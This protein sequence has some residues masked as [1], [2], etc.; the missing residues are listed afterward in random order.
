MV[1]SQSKVMQSVIVETETN[2]KVDGRN[3]R[4]NDINE[5]RVL[6]LGHNI[7]KKMQRDTKYLLKFL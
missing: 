5:T 7:V 2:T 3:N 1:P 4:S 6:K